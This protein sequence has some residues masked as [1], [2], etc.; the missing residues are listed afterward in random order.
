MGIKVIY[1]DDNIVVINKSA[2]LLMH[3]TR[4][5]E[6]QKPD[7]PEATVADWLVKNYPEVRS[8]GD[9][10]S[11]RPGIVH[12]LDKETS[13]IVVAA[14]N[15]KTFDS[16]KSLFQNHE[17]KKTYAALVIGRVES[18]RGIIDK[19]I[20]IKA[21][22]T[23]RSIHSEK[24]QKP[25]KT[26]YRVKRYITVNDRAYTLL[27]VSPQTGRTHQIRVHLASIGHP[28]AGDKMYGGKRAALEGLNRQFLH[29]QT[30][31]FVLE[32]ERFRFEAELP[33]ELKSLLA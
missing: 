23:K 17:I 25:A 19:P 4:L 9:D 31:E 14:R 22:T 5:P 33:E 11:V 27:E 3:G 1:Q 12:R 18:A 30:I 16:L 13:G 15:Q 28:I 10:P 8:V 26:E 29:A 2:G 21:G 20:G 7:K 24:M 32:G 6:N